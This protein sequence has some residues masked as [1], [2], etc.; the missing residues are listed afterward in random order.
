VFW[1]RDIQSVVHKASQDKTQKILLGASAAL[2]TISHCLSWMQDEKK[3]ITPTVP[4]N[5][6]AS[7]GGEMGRMIRKGPC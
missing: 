4:G 1:I 3:G 6:L 5:A 2:A 7:R